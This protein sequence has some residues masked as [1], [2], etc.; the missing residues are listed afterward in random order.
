MSSKDFVLKAPKP[1]D[2]D[3]LFLAT[4]PVP[5]P[6]LAQLTFDL[7]SQRPSEADMA[8]ALSSNAAVAKRRRLLVADTPKIE[9][10]GEQ[11]PSNCKYV[12]GVLDKATGRVTLREALPM[13]VTT[14][15]KALKQTESKT[16]GEK[17]MAAR[18]QLGEAF[19]T[20]KRKQA[21]RAQEKNQVD[22]AGLQAVASKIKEKIE[23]TAA[24]LPPKAEIDA[25]MFLDK[26]IPPCNVDAGTPDSVYNMDDIVTP[27]VLAAVDVKAMWR[28][29]LAAD[30]YQTIQSLQPTDWV[31]TRIEATLQEK[32]DKSRLRKLLY[33]AM[34][35]RLFRISANELNNE[36]IGAKSF[37]GASQPVVDHL[38]RMFCEWQEDE[39]TGKQRRRITSKLKDKL[40]AYI[41]VACLILNN[42]SVDLEQIAADLSLVP[43]KV[44]KVARE[45]GC[46]V[47]VGRNADHDPA[48]SAASGSSKRAVLALPLVFPMRRR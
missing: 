7:Y 21:I 47:E 2:A 38:L 20:K 25:R 26:A 44:V 45:L 39:Q 23:D 34:L 43:S 24:N 35:M 16:I 29:R 18:N 40:L 36:E 48:H 17:N 10:I 37:N 42:F 3:Q 15:V 30:A 11:A 13:T 8:A 1:S 28:S 12:V 9:Y 33:V 4:F 27:E 32:T 41:L 5:P 22:V 14:V 6:R 19:G 46:R 31:W